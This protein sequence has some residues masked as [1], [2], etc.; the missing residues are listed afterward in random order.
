VTPTIISKLSANLHR[1][2]GHPLHTLR[3]LIES[4]YPAFSALSPSSPLVTP[5]QNFDSLSFPP[6]HP[7]RAAT[8]S[9]YIRRD[10]LLRT[11]TSAHEVEVF[12]RGEDK[13]LLTA[14]VYRRDEIDASHYP[15]FH[16]TEGA[17][18]FSTDAAG[19]REIEEDNARLERM[20][21]LE[22]IVIEDVP[23]LTKTNPHQLQHDPRHAE[24]VAK[25]LKLSL[26]TLMLSLF[27]GRS[28]IGTDKGEPLRV[29]WIEAYFPFT[30]PSYEVEVFFNGQWLEILGCGVIQQATLDNAS[31]PWLPVKLLD[32]PLMLYAQK[33]L[34]NLAGLL[35]LGLSEL[36]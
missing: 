6:D 13:W 12:A 17:R 32:I 2:P 18:I 24:L 28:K 14:D 10:V 35:V 33:F 29:R 7:G 9:Y 26:N 23:H 3:G 11:H 31:T 4:T 30:S 16:Q 8:D 22:N 34:I 20:L 1:K 5:Y 36:L 15:V 19:I 25:N 21:A 27:G